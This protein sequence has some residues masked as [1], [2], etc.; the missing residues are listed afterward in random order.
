MDP[1]TMSAVFHM[2]LLRKMGSVWGYSVGNELCRS[3]RNWAPGE[4][5]ADSVI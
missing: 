5:G 3:S 1:L 4:E 2:C